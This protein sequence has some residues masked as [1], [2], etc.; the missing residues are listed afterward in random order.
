MFKIREI[1]VIIMMC[2]NYEKG[3]RNKHK[4]WKK[5]AQIK[6][7]NWCYLIVMV[8]SVAFWLRVLENH[9]W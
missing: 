4:N 3:I 9:G 1:I 7:S 6:K 2:Q 8:D 5:K